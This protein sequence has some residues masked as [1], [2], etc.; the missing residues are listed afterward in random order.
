MDELPFNLFFS[1]PWGVVCKNDLAKVQ[2]PKTHVFTSYAASNKMKPI[3]FGGSLSFSHVVRVA[4]LLV[5]LFLFAQALLLYHRKPPKLRN[6]LTT[7]FT[8]PSLKSS[9]GGGPLLSQPHQSMPSPPSVNDTNLNRIL[10]L[11]TLGLGTFYWEPEYVGEHKY[12]P[13]VFVFEAV[14]V[15]GTSNLALIARTPP[16][17]GM[18]KSDYARIRGSFVDGSSNGG[19]LLSQEPMEFVWGLR[20]D[21]EPVSVGIWHGP[22]PMGLGRACNP[23]RQSRGDATTSLRGKGGGVGGGDHHTLDTSAPGGVEGGVVAPLPDL[24]LKLTYGPGNRWVWSRPIQ[25]LPPPIPLTSWRARAVASHSSSS[26]LEHRL[27]LPPTAL[28]PY[29]ICTTVLTPSDLIRLWVR[30][31]TL[32]GVGAF[33][34]YAVAP[35]PSEAAALAATLTRLLQG[36][37]GGAAITLIPWPFPMYYTRGGD[38][39]YAQ[40]PA[41]NSCVTRYAGAHAGGLLMYDVDEFLVTRHHKSVGEWLGALGARYGH[42][43]PH[44]YVTSMAW[45]VVGATPQEF[46]ATTPAFRLLR[47]SPR[48]PPLVRN[49]SGGGYLDLCPLNCTWWGEGGR[50]G[51]GRF[52]SGNATAG[53]GSSGGSVGDG[54]EEGHNEGGHDDYLHYLNPPGNWRGGGSNSNTSSSSSGGNVKLGGGNATLASHHHPIPPYPQYD[55][56]D[57]GGWSANDTLAE[58]FCWR[59]WAGEAYNVTVPGVPPELVL[60]S[61]RVGTKVGRRVGSSNAT[62]NSSLYAS[63][64]NSTSNTSLNS[65]IKGTHRISNSSSSSSTKGSKNLKSTTTTTNTTFSGDEYDDHTPPLSVYDDGDYEYLETEEAVWERGR[66][67]RR[68]LAPLRPLPTPLGIPPSR[69]TILSL[70]SA[71]ITRTVVKVGGG[72]E[73]YVLPNTSALLQ[74]GGLG[75]PPPPELP[76]KQRGGATGITGTAAGA[77]AGAATPAVVNIHGMYASSR[78]I[79]LQPED[80]YHLHFLNDN[81]PEAFALRVGA[82]LFHYLTREKYNT[83]LSVHP[84]DPLNVEEPLF[85]EEHFT[86]ALVESIR[87]SGGRGGGGAA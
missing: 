63:R 69:L 64:K 35:T 1:R 65:T 31:Y 7:L 71:P 43:G 55:D 70:L 50:G 46:N 11:P 13:L 81:R 78:Q 4:G 16:G 32:K 80:G 77:A 29:A 42:L 5:A 61:D 15:C 87:E 36:Y 45:A 76:Q 47:Q 73:K 41:L 38:A 12:D 68:Y 22:L 83:T 54:K 24:H 53:S 44:T 51:P 40:P 20:L 62:T 21:Y 52:H 37:H 75:L 23:P 6:L 8:S 17:Q 60:K 49:C 72:R 27:L 57:R 3:P 39:N 58:D 19:V 25:I 30:Y 33:Y 18:H 66:N 82:F 10:T 48:P 74:P 59:E 86:Q 79:H 2:L 84:P 28:T 85:L 34:L 56:D 9:V 67:G 14:Y 26:P